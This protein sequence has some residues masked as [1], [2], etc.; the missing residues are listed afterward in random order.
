MKKFWRKYKTTLLALFWFLT[1]ITFMMTI[2]SSEKSRAER[3]C[4]GIGI[5]IDYEQGNYFV[6]EEAVATLVK[7]KLPRNTLNVPV[8]IIDTKILEAHLMNN[9]YVEKAE[10][11]IDI[12]G[13]MWVNIEQH[14]PIARVI[15]T[16]NQ[17]YYLS[18]EGLKMPTKTNFA[19]RVPVI[20]G[21]INDNGKT[22]GSIQAAIAHNIFELAS[23]IEN[24]PFWK[25]MIEQ[26]YVNED[27]DFILTPKMGNHEII[28]GPTYKKEEKFKTLK[29]F[30]QEA[31]PKVGWNTYRSINLKYRGQIVC[32]KR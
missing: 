8:S 26:I 1:G 21:Y 12:N 11:Y 2:G 9:P 10:V 17:S 22:E 30:Y 31:M 24:D 13:K 3:Y 23:F 28:L 15:N 19:S 14:Y 7:Q 18:K 32:T 29:T 20:S 27:R 16:D 25:A 4:S 5:A 6:D